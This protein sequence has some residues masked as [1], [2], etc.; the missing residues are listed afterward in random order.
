MGRADTA[1]RSSFVHGSLVSVSP[2][3]LTDRTQT[4]VRPWLLPR[5]AYV[6]DVEGSHRRDRVHGLAHPL[7]GQTLRAE[8]RFSVPEVSGKGAKRICLSRASS[9]RWGSPTL[10]GTNIRV[11]RARDMAACGRPELALLLWD[12]PVSRLRQLFLRRLHLI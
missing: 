12:P 8:Y 3:K 2:A 10:T 9:Q 4:S 7:A 6:P 1:D 11:N 5:S